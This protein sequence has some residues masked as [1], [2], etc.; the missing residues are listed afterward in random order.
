MTKVIL[1]KKKNKNKK[2]KESSISVNN[3][4]I[5][6]LTDIKHLVFCSLALN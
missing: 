1:K 5:M 3:R 6:L 4:S 2:K